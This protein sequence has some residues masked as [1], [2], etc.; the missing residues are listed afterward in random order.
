MSAHALILE[1][2]QSNPKPVL[3]LLNIWENCTV[4]IIRQRKFT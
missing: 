4:L 2:W 1:H 3:D